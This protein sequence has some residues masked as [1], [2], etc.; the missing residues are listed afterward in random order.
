VTRRRA[1]PGA[2]L[3]NIP[4]ATRIKPSPIT[5]REFY[6]CACKN[7]VERALQRKATTSNQHCKQNQPLFPYK[8]CP[9]FA[10]RRK[11]PR[12]RPSHTLN[13]SQ[14]RLPPCP[15][16]PPRPSRNE[17]RG[18]S[19]RIKN[20]AFCRLA[21]RPYA[22]EGSCRQRGGRRDSERRSTTRRACPRPPPLPPLLPHPPL[23]ACPR[24][25]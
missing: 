20:R 1:P 3:I 15:Q 8:I 7:S 22:G 12:Y 6:A 13:V 2:R 25:T 14:I 9:V 19:Q 23:P 18:A 4:H 10:R 5:A 16:C 11:S 24:G 21:C 17:E